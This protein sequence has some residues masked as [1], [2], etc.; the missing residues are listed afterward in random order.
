MDKR[1]WNCFIDFIINSSLEEVLIE[2]HN[3]PQIIGMYA[4]K[5]I[6][7]NKLYVG[8]TRDIVGRKNQHIRELKRNVHQN[9]DF[10]Q[11]FNRDSRLNFFFIITNTREEAF[12]HEQFILDQYFSKNMLFNEAKDARRSNLNATNK[13][14]SK[15]SSST[16]ETWKDPIVRRNRIAGL[17]RPDVIAKNVEM[18]QQLWQDPDYRNKMIQLRNTEEYLIKAREA[19]R[20]KMKSVFVNGVI[21]D[22]VQDA[23]R[24]LRVKR[25]TVRE[26]CKSEKFSGYY[27]ITPTEAID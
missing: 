8:S 3:K 26:R 18:N 2:C 15:I 22:S 17:N 19:K 13:V 25:H 14:L 16:K 4:F 23:S 20:A 9:K 12:D 6:E 7:T 10:Q 1:I 5:H 24:A 27:F 21:F 11:A